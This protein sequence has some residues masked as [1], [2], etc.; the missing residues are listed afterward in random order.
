MTYM[1]AFADLRTFLRLPHTKDLQ[2]ADVAIVGVPFDT[3][4]SLRVGARFAPG[5]IRMASA[6][7]RP[8]H[9]HFR[10]YPARAVRAVDYG[11]VSVLPGWARETFDLLAETMGAALPATCVPIFLG[12]DHSISLP[13]LR[14]VARHT[15][16][17]A[18]V[19]FDAH[20]DTWPA[21][22]GQPLG[23]GTPFRRALEEGLIDP[24]RSI[25][26]GLRGPVLDEGDPD[27]PR[28][29]GFQVVDMDEAAGMS[30]DALARAIRQRV[31]DG[32]VYLSFDIDAVDPAFAPGTGT[33]E[34][35]GFT[36]REILAVLRRLA[37]LPF[38][39]FDLVEFLPAYD[40]AGVTAI[41][42]A[43]LVFEFLAL[44]AVRHVP[45]R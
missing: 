6:G 30:P 22:S 15:G 43:N 9:P 21:Q 38:A 14:A 42:A 40:P 33:P 18:L 11:D 8:Y 27:M 2:G 41:L 10:L 34:V 31:G 7:L 13:C 5:A 45:T 19:H 24:A 36:S 12:G 23:H 20:T 3:G 26:V 17:L 4:A 39:G 28:Q 29:L 37:G 25:Q 35:G 44:A 1:P 32:P 16:P